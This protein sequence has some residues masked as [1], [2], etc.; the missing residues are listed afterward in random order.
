MLDLSKLN[1]QM[2]YATFN[3]AV[4]FSQQQERQKQAQLAW[5]NT[6]DREAELAE[7]G[8]L[9]GSEMPWAIAAPLEE[10]KHQPLLPQHPEQ[11]IILATDGSQIIPSRHEI[12]PCYLIN[13]GR[14]RLIYGTKE[15]PLLESNPTLYYQER[16]LYT[17][18]RRQIVSTSEQQIAW[19][20]NLKEVE[21]LAQ[22]C[23]E[24]AQKWPELPILAMLDGA[25]LSLVPEL[26]N[27][28]KAIQNPIF[29]RLNKA[30][31]RMQ[32]ANI[33]V[34]SYISRSRRSEIIQFLRL[35][36]CPYPKPQCEQLC[37]E[38]Q[39]ACAG[40]S[41][42]PDREL[43]SAILQ[44][45]QR[46]P[47]FG[48]YQ[49]PPDA[50]LN[51]AM[52]F[53]YINCESEIARVEIPRWVAD[54]PKWVKLIHSLVYAQVEKGRG[55]PIALAEAHNQAVIKSTDRAQFY[56]LLSRKMLAAKMSPSRSYKE[57][58][59]RKGLV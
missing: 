42:L 24:T 49:L 13:I 45:G 26:N 4:D 37:K 25:L 50:L 12:S 16:D 23:E 28:P 51:Q 17:Q 14:I 54:Q 32:K 48:T 31:E 43:W 15:R 59:K 22:L 56:A 58:K 41:P 5:F 3:L 30:F 27:Q 46:S 9:F 18:I 39:E 57:Q 10:L 29:T 7:T 34:C 20:R 21:E 8:R 11:Y 53:F 35:S 33:P 2:G 40:L 55:Y 19:E 1:T 6:L 47:L 38:G 36:R 44:K 52:C